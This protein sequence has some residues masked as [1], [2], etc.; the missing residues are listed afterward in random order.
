MTTSCCNHGSFSGLVTGHAYTLLDVKELSN[1]V[2]LAK[3]RN[4]WSSGEWVGD[5]S[6]T[7]SMWTDALRK[8]AGHAENDK[9]GSFFMTFK[10]YHRNF[11][12]FSV[13]LYQDYEGYQLIN[14][15]QKEY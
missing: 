9:D 10:D 5:W 8:E 7:S 4:P 3:V 15:V 11:R 2:K 12:G 6:D 1:G 14:T 13:S